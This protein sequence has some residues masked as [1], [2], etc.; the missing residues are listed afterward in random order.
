M[1]TRLTR[2]LLYFPVTLFIVLLSPTL[3]AEPTNCEV[4]D[5]PKEQCEVLINLF[6][7]TNGT[8]WTIHTGWNENNTL[9]S[10]EGITC[11]AGNVTEI[12]LSQHGLSG[13]LPEKESWSALTGLEVLDLSDNLL[14]GEIPDL[15]SIPT[16]RIVSLAKNQLE[17]TLPKELFTSVLEELSLESNQ[18]SGIIPSASAANLKKLLL[19]NNQFLGPIPTYSEMPKLTDLEFSDNSSE[20]CKDPTFDYGEWS[21][22]VS[23]FEECSGTI[24]G[25]KYQDI[26]SD[27]LYKSGEPK[28]KG[29]TITLV[30]KAS[31]EVYDTRTTDRYGDYLFSDLPY[32]TY[33]VTSSVPA[34]YGQTLPTPQQPG[35]TVTP[36]QVVIGSE[37][38][39]Y[40]VVFGIYPDN[41]IRLDKNGDGIGKITAR[42]KEPLRSSVSSIGYYGHYV[43]GQVLEL[44]AR[45]APIGSYFVGWWGRDCAVVYDRYPDGT[46]KYTYNTNPIVTV[47]VGNSKIP[48]SATD[49]SAVFQGF[50]CS[51]ATQISIPECLALGAIFHDAN[52]RNWINRD[53]WVTSLEPCSWRGVTCEPLG[54]RGG[55][56]THTVTRVDLPNNN[57][58]GELPDEDLGP[59]SNLTGFNVSGNPDLGLQVPSTLVNNLDNKGATQADLN[60]SDSGLCR[61][62]NT[63]YPEGW[64]FSALPDCP[65]L[66]PIASFKLLPPD[67][68]LIVNVDASASEDP[69]GDIVSY[70]WTTSCG[71][72]AEGMITPIVFTAQATCEITL[73]VTDNAGS[74]ATAKGVVTV[75]AAAL[76]ISRIGDG[77]GKIL[78]NPSNR[79]TLNC[80]PGTCEVTQHLFNPNMTVTL[81]AEPAIGSIFQGWSEDCTGNE[82]S[83]SVVTGETPLSCVAEFSLDPTPP[84]DY[85]K[86]TVI[87][88][89]INTDKPIDNASQILDRVSL[90]H[91]QLGINCGDGYTD[92]Q[93]YKRK[94]LLVRLKSVPND[95]D[96]KNSGANTYWEFSQ[97]LCTLAADSTEVPLTTKIR[98]Q[99]A[100]TLTDET[101]C[102]AYFK[103][104][105]I[106]AAEELREQLYREGELDTGELGSERYSPE[107]GD[108]KEKNEDRLKEGFALAQAAI[109]AIELQ[110]DTTDATTI[111]AT[112]PHHLN[113]I[114]IYPPPPLRAAQWTESVRIRE[115]AIVDGFLS[116]GIVSGLYVEVRVN[117]INKNQVEEIVPILIE[118]EGDSV[119]G[120]RSPRGGGCSSNYGVWCKPP[121]CKKNCWK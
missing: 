40:E 66:P 111:R 45:A 70:A 115:D 49:C 22:K 44:Q 120:T 21:E 47:T 104:E 4:A 11:A 81:T 31:G 93:D 118:Y 113:D 18:L 12:R 90:T 50:N 69:D 99:T 1:K 46:P 74:T 101:V 114:H 3:F 27:G 96:K 73:T 112:W 79:S 30:N 102:V 23:G 119:S 10:W 38:L 82:L 94:G 43:P 98:P 67:G 116:S 97:W 100:F 54:T 86:L 32:G 121:P 7:S 20:L 63:D 52:G 108:G 6:T 87:V 75:P 53:G 107:F 2:W 19:N 48:E 77:S 25:Y 80:S 55:A 24:H 65:Q 8:G 29:E 84:S 110:L 35:S 14:I 62:V 103:S 88:K 37:Q 56:V 117:L 39:T 71:P 15:T 91:P 72:T 95:A 59:L 57:L 16:L 42:T 68:S 106:I 9:C 51:N 89:D 26:I 92:C 17:G 83:V 109:M 5:V 58:V 76:N 41:V 78:V 105:P 60:I 85:A 64:D 61:N 34:G 36:F 13:T 33:T 28:L